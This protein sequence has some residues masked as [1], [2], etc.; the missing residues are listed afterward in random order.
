MK[1][2]L[3]VMLSVVLLFSLS[4]ATNKKIP[5]QWGKL[6]EE[7][8]LSADQE[9][10]IADLHLKLRKEIFPLENKLDQLKSDL[11]MEIVS[12][13]FSETKVKKLVEEIANVEKDIQF[14]HLM[15]QRAIRDLLTVE[16]KKKFD[17]HILSRPG[18]K[19]DD[20]HRFHQRFP[21]QFPP[22]PPKS[23]F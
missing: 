12:E 8:N 13:N 9:S 7:L 18:F 20:R 17:M 6:S 2:F 15:N 22:E 23:E 3:F 11:K 19:Y 21:R 16:Q 5:P 14:K 10:K 4:Y 1:K